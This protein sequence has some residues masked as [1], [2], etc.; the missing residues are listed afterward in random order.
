MTDL[1]QLRIEKD[2]SGR[3][4][5]IT[6]NFNAPPQ[7]VWRAWTEPELLDLWWAPKPWKAQTKSLDFTVG[8]SWLYAMV[9]PDDARHWAR[10]DYLSID[11][12]KSF[13]AMDCFCDE[14]GVGNKDLPALYWK[15]NF[16]PGETGTTVHIEIAFTSLSDFEKIIEMG[17]ESG[18]TA[19]LTNLEHYFDNRIKNAVGN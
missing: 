9:G 3:K 16:L 6:R 10:L 14:N 2:F 18:F 8:G 17:F 1:N 7:A 4:I 15:N 11:P 13:T 19:A 5:T 12:I